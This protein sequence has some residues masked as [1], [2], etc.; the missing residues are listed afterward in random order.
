MRV[1]SQLEE[2]PRIQRWLGSRT[3]RLSR[4]TCYLS[5]SNINPRTTWSMPSVFRG[6][7][8]KPICWSSFP[9]TATR[10]VTMTLSKVV[11]DGHFPPSQ[12][13]L[14][15]ARPNVPSL[16]SW[17]RSLRILKP[18]KIQLRSKSA[19]TSFYSKMLFFMAKIM[20]RW[21]HNKESNFSKKSMTG[22]RNFRLR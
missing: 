1:S 9:W 16:L 8:I 5:L 13:A 7:L 20:A 3:W 4:T 6:P 18:W 2:R 14:K 19:N 22:C 11:V 12:Q 10:R 17:S 15:R 21:T